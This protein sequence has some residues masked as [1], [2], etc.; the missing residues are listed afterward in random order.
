V[1]SGR[2]LNW[3]EY[4][5]A[6]VSLCS[7]YRIQQAPLHSTHFTDL[8]PVTS[9]DAPGVNATIQKG[10]QLLSIHE[11]VLKKNLASWNFDRATVMMGKKSDV[12]KQLQ[13]IAQYAVCILDCV[14]H[15]LELA[16]LDAIISHI[17]RNCKVSI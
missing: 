1:C 16:V 17:W 8:V 15:N 3:Q 4:Y 11:T 5:P 7:V 6:G 10:L 14:A 9:A 12:A 2:W 13:D